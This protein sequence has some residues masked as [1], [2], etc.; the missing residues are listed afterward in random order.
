VIAARVDEA[1]PGE[2]YVIEMPLPPRPKLDG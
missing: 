2:Y 1:E